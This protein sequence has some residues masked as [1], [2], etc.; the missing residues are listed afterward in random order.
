MPVLPLL[1]A[2]VVAA[3]WSASP[4]LVQLVLR[5][6]S[7][8]QVAGIRYFGAFLAL[9]PFLLLRSRKTLARLS[10]SAWARLALMGILSYTI[11]NSLFFWGLGRLPATTGSFLLNAIPI[12]TVVI[13]GIWLG[14]WPNRRQIL[15]AGLTLAGALLF[16]GFR[17]GAGQGPAI[18]VA[19]VGVL[20]MSVFGVMSRSFARSGEIDTVALAAV[21]LFPGGGL[22]LL[23][24]PVRAIPSAEALLVLAWL[25]LVNSALAYILWTH[26]QKRLKA[27][28]ISLVGNLMPMGTALISTL[29]FNQAVPAWSWVGIG[30]ALIG[31]FLVGAA[32]GG[33]NGGVPV[34]PPRG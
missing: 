13:G 29:V 28:E 3:V 24:Q 11:G 31:V 25:A 14:E 21:P 20:A 7:P 18:A 9:L 27:Y 23:L 12:Y 34:V 8:F 4:I 1:E 33:R 19:L 17:V 10:W 32:A 2:L 15:G 26:A 5:E 30:V 6:L 16:F 22:L